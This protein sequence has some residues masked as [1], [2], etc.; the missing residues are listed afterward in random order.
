MNSNV[1]KSASTKIFFQ[2]HDLIIG[3]S[4]I[5]RGP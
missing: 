2:D 1:Q 5:K 4:I 3:T